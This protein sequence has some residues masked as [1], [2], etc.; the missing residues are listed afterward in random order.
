MNTD[1]FTLD[2]QTIA[3]LLDMA[4]PNIPELEQLR[5][6]PGSL[7]FAPQTREFLEQTEPLMTDLIPIPQTRYTA[8]RRFRGDGDR[9]EVRNR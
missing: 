5:S 1:P 2:T 6:E 8:Y 3:A 9:K 4:A 7:A